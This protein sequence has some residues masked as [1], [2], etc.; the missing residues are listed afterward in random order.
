MHSTSCTLHSNN[1]YTY[2]RS[3]AFF[4]LYPMMIRTLGELS[5]S[6]Q[7][8]DYLHLYS[9]LKLSG[10]LISSVSFCLATLVLFD[11]SRRVLRDDYLAYKSCLYFC[12][13][14]ANIFFTAVYTESLFALLSFHCMLKIEQ[15]FSS[16]KTSLFLGM[17]SAL[18][19]NAIIYIG[20]PLYKCLRILAINRWDL[21]GVRLS[22]VILQDYS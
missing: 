10:I 22:I 17:A 8:D 11:L 3:L 20:F 16:L 19:S 6:L 1:G 4:P 21:K 15:S 7:L 14:P 9:C 18:R 2:D 5:Y 13:S 12:I